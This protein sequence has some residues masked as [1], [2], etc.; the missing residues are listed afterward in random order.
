MND[1]F[2]T[3]NCPANDRCRR[4]CTCCVDTYRIYDSCIGQECLR[5]LRFCTTDVYQTILNTASAVRIRDISVLWVR[6]LSEEVP[7]RTGYYSITVRYYFRITLEVCQGLGTT[8]Q[9]IA[10]LACYDKNV[11]LYGGEGT[12]SVYYSDNQQNF[13]S[14]IPDFNQSIGRSSAPRV[15]TEIA[16]PVGLEVNLRES[17]EDDTPL[18][19]QNLP[20]E[21]AAQFEGSFD[22]EVEITQSAY[23]TVGIFTIIRVER[24]AQLMMDNSENCFPDKTCN[25]SGVFTDAC[26]LFSSMQ[27]P[28]EEFAPTPQCNELDLSNDRIGLDPAL[29]PGDYQ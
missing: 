5:N 14:A 4:E 8:P 28:Y 25:S 10:G 18:C 12:V 11:I 6:I 29:D 16:T 23:V 24:P 17:G 1:H 7:F 3:H 22:A 9:I 2:A 27:F 15:V 20:E 19:C 26:T 13:C 21:I